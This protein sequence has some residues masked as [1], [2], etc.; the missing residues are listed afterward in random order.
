MTIP[1]ELTKIWKFLVF[2]NLSLNNFG[3]P[4]PAGFGNL[5]KLKYLDMGGNSFS[6]HLDGVLSQLQNVVHLDLSQNQLSGSI[7]SISDNSAIICA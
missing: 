7:E 6:G 4:V 1:S 2:L 5:K 3:C